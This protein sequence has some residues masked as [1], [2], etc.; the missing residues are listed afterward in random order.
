MTA[1]SL[2]FAFLHTSE[3]PS[4]LPPGVGM[5]FEKLVG[6]RG[7]NFEVGAV[8]RGRPGVFSCRRTAHITLSLL[9]K[10]GLLRDGDVAL[11]S[12][13]ER[14]AFVVLDPRVSNLAFV[15]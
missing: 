4:E 13:T 7:R 14:F 10:P 2:P 9:P 12:S 3:V 1:F 11:R 6:A 8:I 15:V 5:A